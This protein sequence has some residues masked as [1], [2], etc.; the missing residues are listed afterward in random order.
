MTVIMVFSN[1]ICKTLGFGAVP[2]CCLA[3]N[4]HYSGVWTVHATV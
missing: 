1:V 3:R 2:I 4:L